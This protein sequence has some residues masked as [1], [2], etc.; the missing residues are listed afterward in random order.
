MISGIQGLYYF[1]TG[2]WP[3][4]YMDGF[5]AF[6]GPKTDLWLVRTMGLMLMVSG[7]VLMM[8]AAHRR[9]RS[10]ETAALGIG[11]AVVLAGADI[12]FALTGQIPGV[13]LL[14]AAVEVLFLVLWIRY[15]WFSH[16]RRRTSSSID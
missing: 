13:Y 12:F 10:M 4:V 3:I 14:D 8:A 2:L 15:L 9:Q 6:T 16:R 7:M 1:V 5:L 11:V